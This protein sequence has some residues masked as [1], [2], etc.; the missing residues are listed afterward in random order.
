MCFILL[1]A[2]M[3]TSTVGELSASKL[4]APYREAHEFDT[5][6]GNSKFLSSNPINL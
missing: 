5:I 1:R 6:G 4:M 3:D 2:C